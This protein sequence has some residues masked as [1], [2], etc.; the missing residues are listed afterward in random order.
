MWRDVFPIFKNE[1]LVYLDSAAT[2]HKPVSVLDSICNFC[3]TSY[4]NVHRGVYPLSEEA[5]AHYENARGTAAGFINARPEEVIFVRSTTEAVNLVAYSW[6]RAN[7]GPGDRVVVT[8]MEHHSN[9]VPWQQIARETGAS[10]V[11]I[12]LDSRGMLDM[13]RLEEELRR[14]VGLLACTMVSN[15]LGSIV[16]IREI[17]GLAHRYGTTVLVDGAQAAAHLP[18]DVRDIGA[19]F[20][21]FSGHKV[22]GPTGAGILYGRSELLEDMPPFL[23]GGEMISEVHIDYTR[24]NEIPYK[25]E[26]G[27]PPITEAIGLASA[28][29]FIDSIGIEEIRAHE[30]E[31]TH[32]AYGLLETLPDVTIY[33]PPVDDRIGV[34]AF[35]LD[36]VHPHDVAGLLGS[37]GICIR[38]GHHCAQPLH[39]YLGI[40]SSARLSL[41]LYN[42]REDIARFGEEL[43]TVRKILQRAS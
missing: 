23:Y 10:F 43:G 18:V 9:F 14:G 32:V 29:E 38:A 34:I 33:G 25:F 3:S 17:T 13:D 24:F 7:L 39:D 30:R 27:T 15:V 6:G 19:D 42:T 12:G 35:N 11:V 40:P 22:Y 2:T 16:P 21:A 26:A 37:A 1:G 5:T 28:L 8:V 36:G 31:L 4:S 20:F 41:G